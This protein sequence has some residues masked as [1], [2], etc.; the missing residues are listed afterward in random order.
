M[1]ILVISFGKITLM[2]Y[3]IPLP[4]VR[5]CLST[6]F[7]MLYQREKSKKIPWL[8][9]NQPMRLLLISMKFQTTRLFLELNTRFRNLSL[10]QLFPLQMQRQSCLPTISV[11]MILTSG[12]IVWTRSLKSSAWQIP[13]GTMPL[14]LVRH[15]TKATTRLNVMIITTLTRRQ[16]VICLSWPITLSNITLKSLNTLANRQ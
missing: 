13:N 4:W 1:P 16:P 11:I 9:P 3:V 6:W 14:E 7:L 5:P 15:L 10:W 8:Q 12:L 2:K